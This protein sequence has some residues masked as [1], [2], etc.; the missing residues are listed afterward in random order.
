MIAHR[1]HPPSVLGFRY[2]RRLV[3]LDICGPSGR[4]VW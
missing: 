3:P 2:K 1:D 4:I